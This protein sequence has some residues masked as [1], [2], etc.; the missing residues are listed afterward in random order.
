MSP[1]AEPS[2]VSL[3]AR[4]QQLFQTLVD[5][6]KATFLCRPGMTTLTTTGRYE[7]EHGNLDPLFI[8]P[9]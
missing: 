9:L 1:C 4:L 6:D 5:N 8:V 2:P 3:D 7:A